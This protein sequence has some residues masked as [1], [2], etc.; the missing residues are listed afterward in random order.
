[1]CLKVQPNA[2]E[3]RSS[4][5]VGKTEW[6]WRLALGKVQAGEKGYSKCG[7]QG[8]ERHDWRLQK[9][10]PDAQRSSHCHCPHHADRRG[11]GRSTVVVVNAVAILFLADTVLD[12]TRIEC[13]GF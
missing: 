11:G 6:H 5:E 2:A 1:V 8:G 12:Q 7:Q 13:I 4:K 10:S 3:T 9:S